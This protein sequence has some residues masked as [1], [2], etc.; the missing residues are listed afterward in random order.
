MGSGGGLCGSDLRLR[1]K[2]QQRPNREEEEEKKIRE[3][4][5]SLKGPGGMKLQKGQR[6]G[7]C[8]SLKRSEGV[9]FHLLQTLRPQKAP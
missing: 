5:N 9:M 7:S 6:P 8:P 4:S 1:V 3:Q 2:R